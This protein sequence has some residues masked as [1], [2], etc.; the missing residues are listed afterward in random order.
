MEGALLCLKYQHNI[1][2]PW[3]ILSALCQA[4]HSA[5]VGFWGGLTP[6]PTP[7]LG[8]VR[9]GEDLFL[10]HGGGRHSG[11]WKSP[12]ASQQGCKTPPPRPDSRGGP[13]MAPV[14]ALTSRDVGSQRAEISPS[15]IPQM[16]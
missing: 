6:S 16:K 1:C 13:V 10:R 3:P 11:T 2:L 7:G 4:E 8:Q 9:S 12:D 15:E 5:S 14:L